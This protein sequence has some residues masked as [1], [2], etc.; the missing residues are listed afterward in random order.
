M[1]SIHSL[2]PSHARD[3]DHGEASGSSASLTTL[4]Q[5]W[6]SIAATGFVGGVMLILLVRLQGGS[7]E[8]VSSNDRIVQCLAM[9]LACTLLLASLLWNRIAFRSV[10]PRY[11]LAATLGALVSLVIGLVFSIETMRRPMDVI[12][13]THPAGDRIVAPSSTAP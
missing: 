8:A 3:N 9:V 10:A 5:F 12:V 1:S 11:R 6:L 4:L 2:P 7:D 13:V